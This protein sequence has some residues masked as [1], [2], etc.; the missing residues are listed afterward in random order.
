MLA[1]QFMLF[2]E[3]L[4]RR[5]QFNRLPNG[6]SR[7]VAVKLPKPRGLSR[8]WRGDADALKIVSAPPLVPSGPSL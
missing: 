5:D 2:L 3:N 8:V 1:E 6:P 4:I 7:H